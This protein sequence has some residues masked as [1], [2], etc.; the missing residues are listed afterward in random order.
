MSVAPTYRHIPTTM[1]CLRKSVAELISVDIP[2]KSF[3][4]ELLIFKMYIFRNVES[5]RLR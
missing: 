1:Q 3:L 4:F 5:Y 2:N